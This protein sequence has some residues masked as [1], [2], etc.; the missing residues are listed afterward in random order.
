MHLRPTP[1]GFF[2]RPSFDLGPADLRVLANRPMRAVPD[3]GNASA[4]PT[5]AL[6]HVREGNALL[7]PAFDRDGAASHAALQQEPA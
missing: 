5:G 3:L 6:A 1:S 4:L 7:N 2:R